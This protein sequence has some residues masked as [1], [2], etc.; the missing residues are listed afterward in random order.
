MPLRLLILDAGAYTPYYDYSLCKALAEAGCQ[1][2]WITAPFIYDQ[3]PNRDGLDIWYGFSRLLNVPTPYQLVFHRFAVL[4]RVI[5]AVEY[6]LDWA[7][8]FR[9][10][11][12]NPP[13]I[14][15]VQW[16][17]NPTLDVVALGNL[18]RLGCRIV[19]TAHNVLPHDARPGDRIR[20]ARLYRLADAIIALSNHN[21]QQ[22]QV[23]FQVPEGKVHLVPM[24]N[25]DDFR[26][27]PITR[28]EA[29]ARLGLPAGA[30]VILFFGLIKP[31]KGLASLIRAFA[32]V[33][34]R[35][36]EAILLI[37][38]YPQGGF[39][40]YH[41][42]VHELGLGSAVRTA[43]RYV[44]HCEMATWFTAADVVALPYLAT[45][46]SAVLMT[47]YTFGR[48]VVATSVG[49]LPEAVDPGQSGLL[50][51]PSDEA[52]LAEAIIALL[53]DSH[54]C[55]QMGRYARRLAETRYSWQVI[56]SATLD[57]YQS[58]VKVP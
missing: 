2:R 45:S 52:A 36:P 39:A 6:P 15:H 54:R 53:A 11:R 16:V 40:P 35:L 22:L 31:Y 57:V 3:I 56:A 21:R 43:L 7:L 25:L 49:G 12:R 19:Y 44:S 46:Q 18:R 41:R 20:Y 51:P 50:V 32:T 48:P 38:G 23:L 33:Q 42:L 5:K 26:G 27:P 13:D 9:A 55:T 28:R 10:L 47:A 4:R 14:L 17:V 1:V 30:P 8:L 29:R 24:G 34:A 37:V 58:L